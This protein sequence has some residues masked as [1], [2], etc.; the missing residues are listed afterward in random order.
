LE[1]VPPAP[2]IDVVLATLPAALVALSG[3]ASWALGLLPGTRRAA[4]RD[5]LTG[6]ARRQLER[7]IDHGP[8]IEARWLILR[9]IGVSVTAVLVSRYLPAALGGWV[10]AAAALISVLAYAVPAEILK[11]LAGRVPERAAPLLLQVL[12]PIEL[13]TAPLARATLWLGERVGSVVS[14]KHT[15]P[16]PAVTETEVELIVTEGEMTG[17]LG[18]EQ[19]EM[20]R[21][22][23]EFGD[24]TA[25]DVMVPR[26]QTKA[27]SVVTPV[28]EVLRQVSDAAHS[29]YPVYR[30]TIDN[31]IGVLHAKDLLRA[32]AGGET[33]ELEPI[34]RPVAFVP[35]SQTAVSVLKDMRAGRHHL[36]VVIDEFGGFSGIV[37][38]E[39]L[40]EQIV[41]D[42]RDEH[43][44]EEAPIADLGDGRMVVDAS[45]PIADLSRYLGT[46]LPDEGDYHTLGGFVVA[47]FGRVPEVGASLTAH[48]LDFV[49]REGDERRVTKVEIHR[50][51]P[52]QSILPRST[53]RVS[54]A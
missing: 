15:D 17:A 48:G 42:I 29:R 34:L 16:P 33:K 26:T 21:N 23:L 47:R 8:L 36:A 50:Q 43:D 52:P 51:G 24:V 53:T 5:G 1:E 4:L 3:A 39:D 41:G 31:V 40:L 28:E 10:P 46:E 20:I 25:R 6:S 22:V 32:V 49:V 27:F 35:E 13:L 30:D 2:V 12:W 44:A 54:A 9:A 7:Y 37:T 38:L 14:K 18:H 19:G 45:V 11:A